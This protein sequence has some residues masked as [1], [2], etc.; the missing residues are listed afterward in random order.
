MRVETIISGLIWNDSSTE[1]VGSTCGQGQAVYGW[2]RPAPSA[3]VKIHGSQGLSIPLVYDKEYLHYGTV[4]DQ[5][6]LGRCTWVFAV[7]CN[8]GAAQLMKET[9]ERIKICSA[10]FVKRLVDRA[11]PG[12]PLTHM[13]VPPRAISGPA[14]TQYFQVSK[15]GPCWDH[16]VATR[17]VGVYVPG[18]LFTDPEIELMVVLDT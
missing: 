9:P 16:I 13:P 5:R 8:I 4:T 2:Q 1:R 11:L 12:L 18:E 10:E 6:C 15:Q 17:R 3:V 14:E 7:R